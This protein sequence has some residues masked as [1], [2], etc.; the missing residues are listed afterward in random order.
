M[1]NPND[2]TELIA[3]YSSLVSKYGRMLDALIE[4][5]EREGGQYFDEEDDDELEE[6]EAD[7]YG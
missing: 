5:S 1:E 7:D 4:Q 3:F 2:L 6:Q